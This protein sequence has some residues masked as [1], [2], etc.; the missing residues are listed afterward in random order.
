MRFAALLLLLA[1]PVVARAAGLSVALDEYVALVDAR[2]ALG[3]VPGVRGDNPRYAELCRREATALAPLAAIA[4]GTD[5]VADIVRRE[6]VRRL[7]ALDT[8]AAVATEPQPLEGVA[9]E[10]GALLREAPRHDAS[11]VG[12]VPP[13]ARLR[14]TG[15]AGDWYQLLAPNGLRAYAHG[16]LLDV[17]L[18]A[19]AQVPSGY[20]RIADQKPTYYNTARE[21]GFPT[22]GPLFGH[23]YDGTEKAQVQTPEGVVIATTSGRYFASL[24]M[25]GSGILADGRGV[26]FVSAQRFQLLPPGCKGIT[27]TGRWVVPFH[28]LAVNKREMSYNNVY[29]VPRSKGLVLPNG[30]THDGFWFAHDTGSAFSGTAKHRTDLY[31][32]QAAWVTWMELNHAPSFAP[33]PFYRVDPA[34]AKE[35]YARYKDQL[36]PTP[37]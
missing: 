13:F 32:D 33:V 31:V 29:F 22:A 7:G 11:S 36:G 17:D 26:S 35:V 20:T 15:R 5:D 2:R 18:D 8:A 21:I 16:S 23:T 1:L 30:E 6:L 9:S 10:D 37:R 27:A 34:T 25:E 4:H 12:S 19:G 3:D 14:I 24:C 28:T